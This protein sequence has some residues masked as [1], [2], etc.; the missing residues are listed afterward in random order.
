MGNCIS[1]RRDK[2]GRNSP[3]T[4][5]Q[6][7]RTVSGVVEN[8]NNKISDLKKISYAQNTK[9]IRGQSVYVKSDKSYCKLAALL[10]K[11]CQL[12]EDWLLRIVIVE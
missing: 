11:E 12:S 7:C 8:I 3:L 1:F 10:V 4:Q 9:P 6:L 2:K 5:L